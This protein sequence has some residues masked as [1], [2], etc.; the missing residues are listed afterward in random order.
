MER[1]LITGALGQLG[2][3]LVIELQNIYGVNHV[4]VS[5]I[6]QPL[7]N[8]FD[9][10]FLTLDVL[11][12]PGLKEVIS[13]YRVTQIYH[14][15]AILSANAEK[16]PDLAWRIN[17]DGLI[18]ILELSREVGI[19]KVYWPSSIAVFGPDAPKD[20]TPQHTIMNPNTIY[21]ISKVAGE[22]LCSYYIERY[23]MDV[24]SLRYPGLIGH[25]GLPG[26]GTTDYAV[27]IYHEALRNGK[28]TCPLDKHARLPMMFMPDAVRATLELME[29]ERSALTVRT[30]YNLAGISFTPEEITKSI[31]K[32]IPY[33]QTDYQPDFRQKIAASWPN[34][35]DDSAARNDWKWKVAY[36][37]DGMTKEMISHLKVKKQAINVC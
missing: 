12:K 9:G 16:T 5:D 31:Q 17:M 19:K 23:G 7:H 1:I 20:Q 4:I 26:G 25:R 33:F 6:H 37:L 15:A 30:S 11:D 29:A 3:E 2:T 27:E 8:H 34:S 28:F 24:R 13:K 10:V 35:I 22:N 21:G 36:D 32:S 18:N 14:L